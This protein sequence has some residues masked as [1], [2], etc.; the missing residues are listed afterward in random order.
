MAPRRKQ[1]WMGW[2]APAM[3]KVAGWDFDHRL[4]GYITTAADRF[5]CDCGEEF[6]TPSGYRK[7]GSCGRAWNS[8]VI[9]SDS[10]GKEAA[11]EKVI[12]REIPVRKDVIVASKRRRQATGLG[13]SR[14]DGG[15]NPG[16]GNPGYADYVTKKSKD[17]WW[18]SQV[19]ENF[20]SQVN[21]SSKLEFMHTDYSPLWARPDIA[22]PKGVADKAPPIP[23][24]YTEDINWE[25]FSKRNPG[26]VSKSQFDRRRIIPEEAIRQ[27]QEDPTS[28]G[29]W[30]G[31]PNSKSY[32]PHPENQWKI[33]DYEAE[34]AERKQRYEESKRSRNASARQAKGDC[35]CWDGYERVPGTKPCASGSC[36]KKAALRY[37][38]WCRQVDRRPSVAGLRRF[39]T[40]E[41][42]VRLAIDSYAPNPELAGKH[43]KP[44]DAPSY[45]EYQ[46][47]LRRKRPRK[48]E[49]VPG[50]KHE[51]LSPFEH[52]MTADRHNLR[53]RDL[54]D[55]TPEERK[56]EEEV[57]IE[58]FSSRRRRAE[59]FDITDE[60]ETKS[61]KGKKPNTPTMRKNPANWSA[62][63]QNGQFTKR[64]N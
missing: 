43:M 11:L 52:F 5:S 55:M 40:A 6:S 23:G 26:A 50:A 31:Y 30:S 27:Y 29:Q 22:V 38:A 34:A 16:V 13:Y 32:A 57:T 4:N 21:N 53:R 56:P 49:S 3:K 36:R 19:G 18:K 58:H 15:R 28:G 44:E 7:C 20:D 8:Y 48:Q 39:R 51:G 12:V 24:Y 61:G 10:H 45:N 33:P 25:D 14:S 63:K 2:G 35:E 60:G 54:K 47:D 46:W 17:P 42:M 62:H 1:A 64:W 37:V 41:R 59:L 9:G